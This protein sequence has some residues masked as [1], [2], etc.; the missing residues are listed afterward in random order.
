MNKGTLARIDHDMTALWDMP[1]QETARQLAHQLLRETLG[2]ITIAVVNEGAGTIDWKNIGIVDS[3]L[4][5]YDR[6]TDVSIP[7]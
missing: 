4:D 1:D 5:A 6:L 2:H 7:F 3:I